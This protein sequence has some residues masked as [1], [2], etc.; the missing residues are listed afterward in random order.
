M[1]NPSDEITTLALSMPFPDPSSELGDRA[2]LDH[3]LQG[4]G[5]GD[6]MPGIVV[7]GAT[8]VCCWW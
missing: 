4:S 2:L 6:T 7:D 8:L 3:L 5:I 1:F